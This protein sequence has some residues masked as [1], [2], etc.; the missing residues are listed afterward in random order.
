MKQDLKV[1]ALERRQDGNQTVKAQPFGMR[2]V[3]D[4][5]T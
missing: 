3:P 1:L 5:D 2:Q 4:K